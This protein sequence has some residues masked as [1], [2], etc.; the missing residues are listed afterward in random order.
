MTDIR[1]CYPAHYEEAARLLQLLVGKGITLEQGV[2]PHLVILLLDAQCFSATHP[3]RAAT[4]AVQASVALEDIE[5]K[6]LIRLD[7][8]RRQ[9]LIAL[10]GT[11][12]ANHKAA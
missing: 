10:V 4:H 9:K 2:D 6:R 8:K 7:R 11:V 5:L 3:L 1:Q 12:I